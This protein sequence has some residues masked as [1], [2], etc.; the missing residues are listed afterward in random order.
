MGQC[1]SV[2]GNYPIVL[3]TFPE[4]DLTPYREIWEKH[5]RELQVELFDRSNFVSFEAY[6]RFC[7][8][9]RFYL[10]FAEYHDYMLIY[11]PDAWVFRDELEK[12]CEEGWDY[13]GAPWVLGDPQTAADIRFKAVGNGGFSLRKIDFCLRTLS[14][15]GLILTPSTL[16]ALRDD[17]SCGAIVRKYFIYPTQGCLRAA[18]KRNR[19]Y[20]DTV[21]S[22]QK[23]TALKAR[24][25]SPERASEFSFDFHPE[26]LYD[27]TGG[28]LP[29]GCHGLEY[30]AIH[31]FWAPLIP[32][33]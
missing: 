20:E 4:L 25:P 13:V 21:F 18:A 3:V 1:L 33:D 31:A 27:F 6:N 17:R 9:P 5:G 19:I 24:I 14:A 15:K 30:R 7:L 28:R 8:D 10:R 23:Y 16:R 26:A 32:I 11:Q 2:F 29:F 22:L 12:W